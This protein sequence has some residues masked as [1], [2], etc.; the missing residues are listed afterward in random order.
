MFYFGFGN[1]FYS[2]S[3]YCYLFGNFYSM[4]L[5]VHTVV[6][7]FCAVSF[8]FAYI[9]LCSGI[10][11]VLRSLLRYIMCGYNR[12]LVRCYFMYTM[13]NTIAGPLLHLEQ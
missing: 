8:Y 9:L 13:Y 7:I 4:F 3:F 5:G 1:S 10:G 11:L 6:S 12:L 2:T